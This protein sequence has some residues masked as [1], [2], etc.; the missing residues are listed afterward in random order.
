MALQKFAPLV[1]WALEVRAG[2]YEKTKFRGRS[3]L[4]DSGIYERRGW[5]RADQPRTPLKC[6]KGVKDRRTGAQ[7]SR[8]KVS[9]P[10]TRRHGSADTGNGH[11]VGDALSRLSFAVSLH[12]W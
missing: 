6:D 8:A 2:Q 10:E 7:Y 9:L 3:G 12:P 11:G 4:L 5:P 1:E